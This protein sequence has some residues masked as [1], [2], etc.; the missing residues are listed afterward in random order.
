MALLWRGKREPSRGPKPTLAIEQ[1]IAAAVEIADAEGLGAVTMR[2]L[3]DRVSVGAMTLYTYVPGKAELL[4]VMLDEV[5][6]ETLDSIVSSGNWR[7]RLEAQARRD[8]ELYRRH[9]WILQISEAR[10]LL[11][12]NEI[13]LYESALES[14]AGLGLNG[15]E[16]I[17]VV[18]L[19]TSYVRGAAQVAVDAARVGEQTGVSDEQWWDERAPILDEYYEVTRYPTLSSIDLEGAFD[20][21]TN[22]VEY[23]LQL[24]IDSFEF[25]LQ[26]VLDGIGAFINQRSVDPTFQPPL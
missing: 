21:T 13:A 26:R 10:S 20:P 16:M 25:G 11:G 6:G 9:P 19:V 18:S 7:E 24:A 22:G 23:H 3:A 5:Y 8:W 14:V 2:R 17:S 12:P 1:I 4:D 15:R